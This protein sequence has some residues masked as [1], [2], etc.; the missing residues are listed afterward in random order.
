M[1][2][3]AALK[4]L[5][6]EGIEGLTEPYLREVADFV[7]FIRHKVIGEQPY[8]FEGIRQELHELSKRELRHLEEEFEDF[9]WPN[10]F[11]GME[12]IR[13]RTELLPVDLAPGTDVNDIID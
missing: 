6:T 5:I 11:E 9:N 12:D 13:K 3:S 10:W 2:T 1:S 8:D 4:Q 7:V